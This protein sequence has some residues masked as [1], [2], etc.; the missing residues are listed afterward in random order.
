MDLSTLQFYGF[1]TSCILKV[2]YYDI[3]TYNCNILLMNGFIFHYEFVFSLSQM[4]LFIVMYFL[5]EISVSIHFF[6]YI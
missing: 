4:I 2:C 1:F 5:S 3:S 6:W